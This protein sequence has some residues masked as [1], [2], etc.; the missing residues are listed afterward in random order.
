MCGAMVV[1]YDLEDGS[2]LMKP[3][4]GAKDGGKFGVIIAVAEGVD[5]LFDVLDNVI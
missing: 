4:V 1:E 2:R 5:R 3:V